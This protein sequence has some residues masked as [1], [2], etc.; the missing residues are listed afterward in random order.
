MK[1]EKKEYHIINREWEGR[2][3]ERKTW[4]INN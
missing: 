2:D 1:A 3:D 4:K